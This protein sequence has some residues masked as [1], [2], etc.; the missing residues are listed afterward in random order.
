MLIEDNVLN[1]RL[2]VFILERDGFDISAYENAEDA[3]FDAEKDAPDIIL[4]DI[5]LPGMDGLTAT[6]H[7]KEN[8]ATAD[9]PVVAITAHAMS[10]DRERILAAGCAGYISKPVDTRELTNAINSYLPERTEPES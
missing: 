5:Q 3:I 8:T 1:S 10:G 9:I 2:I 4:M 6:R 7:L